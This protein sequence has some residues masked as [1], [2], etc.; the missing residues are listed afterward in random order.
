[1]Y[2]PKPI[3]QLDGSRSQS[4]NCWAAVG[5]WLADGASKGRKRLKPEVFRQK[6]KKPANTT[7][8]LADLARGLTTMKLWQRGRYRNDLTRRQMRRRFSAKSRKLY[9]AESD[10]KAYP[11]LKKCQPGFN[12]YHAIGIKPGLGAKSKGRAKKVRVMNPLCKR[13][14]WVNV[15]RVIDA[16]ISYNNKHSGEKKNT[17]DLIVVDVPK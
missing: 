16:I 6:S 5:A 15:D 13:W 3:P 12:G 2:T 1:M 14:T 17:A 7:G 11:P 10:F 9:G 4:K 8:G